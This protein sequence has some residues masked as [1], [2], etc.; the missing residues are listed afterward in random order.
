MKKLSSTNTLNEKKINA[1]CGMGYA[2][3]LI[4]GR[5][6]SNI[7]W[8]L[9]NEGKIRYS[10]LRKLIP[11][12]SERML[13][14]QLRELEADQLIN[15]IIYPEVPPRVEYELTELGQSMHDMLKNISD[16]GEMHRN[17]VSGQLD[18]SKK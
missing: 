10:T 8:R 11:D 14:A 15:R 4:G 13:V 1:T 6:K 2:L 18:N 7:L 3:S 9:L 5:W 17:V 12:I 16:W